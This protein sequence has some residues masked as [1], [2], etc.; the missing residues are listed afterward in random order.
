MKSTV[1]FLTALMRQ[2]YSQR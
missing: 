1:N 2:T